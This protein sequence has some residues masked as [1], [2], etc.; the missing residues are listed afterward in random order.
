VILNILLQDWTPENDHL[1]K[2]LPTLD[3]VLT[4]KKEVIRSYK[5]GPTSDRFGKGPRNLYPNIAVGGTDLWQ[6]HKESECKDIPFFY[7]NVT[8]KLAKTGCSLQPVFDQCA[9]KV[10]DSE[11]SR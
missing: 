8:G 10:L 9:L 5:A 3:D 4:Y 7:D 6:S 2:Y 11:A 1:K